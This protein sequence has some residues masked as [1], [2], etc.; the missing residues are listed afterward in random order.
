MGK[1]TIR[2]RFEMLAREEPRYFNICRSGEQYYYSSVQ[3]SWVNWQGAFGDKK[4]I[5]FVPKKS[6]SKMLMAGN[7][8]GGQSVSCGMILDEVVEGAIK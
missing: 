5:V 3:D 1:N 2:D 8:N 6:N 7:R 4:G